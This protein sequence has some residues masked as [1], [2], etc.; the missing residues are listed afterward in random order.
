MPSAPGF[1]WREKPTPL[2]WLLAPLGALYGAVT[3][4]RMRRAGTPAGLPVICVGNF[5][6]GG[7]GKTPTAIALVALLRQQRQTPFVLMRGYGGKLAGPL[8]VDPSRHTA[9][10]VGD[11]PLL[12]ARHARTVIA[13]DRV[14][15]AALARRAGA[16]LIVMD[17]G[18]QNPALIK[19]FKLAVVDGGSGV[20]NRLCLPAGP[21]RAPLSGQL[22]EIDAVLVIGDGEAGDRVARLSQTRVKGV[23][24]ARLLPDIATANRLRGQHVLA[25]SGIGRPEKFRATLDGIGAKIVAERR[26]SD[27]HAYSSS[28][29]AS[30]VAQAKD[31][32]TLVA[33][34]E[35]DMTK[36]S[37][38]WPASDAAMLVPVPVTLVFEDQA[39]VEA[40]L[41]SALGTSGAA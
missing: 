3:L 38:L 26:L 17:D 25:L 40:L 22:A 4:R 8:E 35:K 39:A 1:W 14:A 36:L 31:L 6:A 5:I 7:A 23:F 41:R 32:D 27:H 16:S 21:L 29:V 24:K 13:R 9:A 30:I 12:M 10:E 20:G 19:D 28:D 15:G 34:T 33:T 18:L 37:G 2:A 11:E